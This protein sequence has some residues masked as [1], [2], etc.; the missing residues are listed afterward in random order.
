[1]QADGYSLDDKRNKIDANDLSDIV[2][3]WNS[4]SEQT[5]NDRSSKFFFVEK[6]EIENNDLDLSINRYKLAEYKEVVYQDPKE[7]LAKI[8]ALEN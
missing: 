1:M 5:E 8:E 4:R 2:A 6:S 7:I 3:R